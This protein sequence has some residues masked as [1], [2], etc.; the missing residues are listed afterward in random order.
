MTA[1]VESRWFGR[2]RRPRGPYADD[3]SGGVE[4]TP[5]RRRRRRPRGR[6]PRPRRRPRDARRARDPPAPT[7]TRSVAIGQAW[8]RSHRLRFVV[9]FG[10]DDIVIASVIEPGRSRGCRIY[11]R[12]ELTLRAR[13]RPIATTGTRACRD[14]QRPGWQHRPNGAGTCLLART[15]PRKTSLAPR[16]CSPPAKLTSGRQRRWVGTQ[17]DG[18]NSGAS[19]GPGAD[20]PRSSTQ[21]RSVGRTC[22]LRRAVA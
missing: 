20:N 7:A 10:F 13:V 19:V 8:S 14:N 12:I 21:K 3:L 15:Y 11:Q 2:A 18:S 16:T 9:A 6:L 1:Q 22:P 5:R 4:P 17:I